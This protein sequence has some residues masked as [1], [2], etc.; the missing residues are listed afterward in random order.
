MPLAAIPDFIVH[1]GPS[2]A[3]EE[4]K[5]SRMKNEIEDS[6]KRGH[7]GRQRTAALVCVLANTETLWER[8]P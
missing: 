6:A 8:G 4:K 2:L 7:G 5:A 3:A 1:F